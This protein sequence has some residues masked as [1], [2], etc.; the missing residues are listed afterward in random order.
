MFNIKRIAAV[1]ISYLAVFAGTLA[2]YGYI[3]NSGTV[4]GSLQE[5]SAAL[6]LLYVQSGG[7]LIN[8]MHGYV[9]DIDGGYLRDTMTPVDDSRTVNLVIR[10]FKDHVSSAS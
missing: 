7:S 8:E 3:Q 10:D 9:S 2:I 6:P 1:I 5:N 4:S